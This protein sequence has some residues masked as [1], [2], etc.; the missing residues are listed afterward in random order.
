[1]PTRLRNRTDSRYAAGK[2][3]FGEACFLMNTAQTIMGMSY[4]HRF[5]P[6]TLLEGIEARMQVVVGEMVDLRCEEVHNSRI[7]SSIWDQ[8]GKY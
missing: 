6:A 8:T 2:H 5:P 4:T 7:L 1:M 3:I